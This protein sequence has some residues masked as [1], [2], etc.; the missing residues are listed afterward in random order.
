MSKVAEY[1]DIADALQ[2]EAEAA[3]VALPVTT[4]G[5]VT[6]MLASL[7][8]SIFAFADTGLFMLRNG[9][10]A[11]I[12]AI[13]RS[14]LEAWVDLK[15]L[16]ADDNYLDKM[17]ASFFDE[18]IR[19][20]E[21]GIT[22]NNP[23]SASFANNAKVTRG[24]AEFKAEREKLRQKGIKKPPSAKGKFTDA[25][26]LDIYMAVYNSLCAESHNNIRA[27]RERHLDFVDRNVKLTVFK[28]PRDNH[29]IS[30][31]DLLVE[32]VRAGLASIYANQSATLPDSFLAV[33]S[34]VLAFRDGLG[35]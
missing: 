19:M 12:S 1:M 2:G 13:G 8:A 16:S 5:Q 15:N 23:F 22:G 32:P 21:D 33:D 6:M 10:E 28:E 9:R 20:I 11:G 31:L 7:Y 25:G 24:L 29:L 34:R 18:Y 4:R 3:F 17:Q 27:L 35:V 30:M 26:M 14:S